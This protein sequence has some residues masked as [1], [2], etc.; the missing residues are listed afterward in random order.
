[1]RTAL[2][3]A[4]KRTGSGELRAELM[5]AGR[6][7]L[8]WQ[9]DLAVLLGCER[10]ICLCE[11]PGA[12]VIARQRETEA[13]GLAFHAVRGHLQ[14]PA[15][16]RPEDEV[17]LLRDGLVI[18]PAVAREQ[19][20]S[21]GALRQGVATLEAAHALSAA[22]PEDFE[23][24]DRERHWA[25]LAVMSGHEV[26]GLA[27]L[28]PDAETMSLLVRLALQ[29]RLQCQ[30][31]PDRHLED[32]KWL[33]AQDGE[34]LERLSRVMVENGLPRS[35]WTG[36][37]WSLAA[38][39]AR[40][41]G[42][43]RMAMGAEGWAAGG[44]GVM[45]VLA[46]V[47]AAFG[48]GASGL[49]LAAIG[50]FAGTLAVTF[51]EL[52]RALTPERAQTR[53]TKALQG[54]MPANIVLLLASIVLILAFD[55]PVNFLAKL[56]MPVLAI[57][58]GWLANRSGEGQPVGFWSDHALHFAG[59]AALFAFGLLEEGVILFALGALLHLMLNA[60]NY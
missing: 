16:I 5:L 15:L 20:L 12:Q 53:L 54:E 32:D 6:S 59:F 39:C 18:D 37:G 1:M 43:R 44:A 4:I 40:A 57:G 24:I 30:K 28:P 25:G 38:A 8:S 9:V 42:P 48:Y 41:L 19:V 45:L 3:S 31:V 10:I 35:S 52:R 36:P 60:R 49:A 27:D 55:D 34:A 33:L 51:A 14:L 21:N 11:A 22:F 23:R 17:L 2:V 26:H 50:L 47:L 58:L 46:G 7:V 13:D 56:G 29:A